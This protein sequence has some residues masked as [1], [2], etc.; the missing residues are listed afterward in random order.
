M[1]VLIMNSYSKKIYLLLLTSAF[2]LS[3][4]I[5]PAGQNV[6]KAALVAGGAALG[7]VASGLHDG[8]EK[9]IGN[10]SQ[11]PI[12]VNPPANTPA[13]PTPNVPAPT[14]NPSISPADLKAFSKIDTLLERAKTEEDFTKIYTSYGPSLKQITTSG[15]LA[16]KEAIARL[17]KLGDNTLSAGPIEKTLNK[18]TDYTMKCLKPADTFMKNY[19]TL[20][21]VL[22]IYILAGYAYI[23]IVKRY[24]AAQLSP[25]TGINNA[26]NGI[27]TTST[28]ASPFDERNVM[29]LLDNFFFLHVLWGKTWNNL[30]GNNKAFFIL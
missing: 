3:S 16:S 7:V 2:F 10:M 30:T 24:T 4:T 25:V 27:N 12:S 9:V 6:A 22:A 14:I 8:I 19:P 5:K 21:K 23:H 28:M 13:I 20:S 1:G 26:N 29:P 11:T 17:E 18:I 15:P